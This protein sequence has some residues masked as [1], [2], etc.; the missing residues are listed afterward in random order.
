MT[1]FLFKPI[2][3]LDNVDEKNDGIFFRRFRSQFSLYETSG[4]PKFSNNRPCSLIQL[5]TNPNLLL[6]RSSKTSSARSKRRQPS[7]F[8]L[9][10]RFFRSKRHHSFRVEFCFN[11]KNVSWKCKFPMRGGEGRRK[12]RSALDLIASVMWRHF[13]LAEF[14]HPPTHP[15]NL[16]NQVIGTSGNCA[17]K[18]AWHN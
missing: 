13:L 16:S 7:V 3:N 2:E 5:M 10:S 1:F 4:Y 17:S 15:S 6:P 18:G 14:F 11:P 12:R 9:A 8:K